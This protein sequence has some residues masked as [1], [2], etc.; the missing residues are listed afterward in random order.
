MKE[1]N[2]RV[3]QI[4]MHRRSFRVNE[5]TLSYL[6]SE[7]DKPV[8]VALHAHWM[9][10]ST[11]RHFASTLESSWRIVALDQR[12]HGYSDHTITY[13]R[14]DYINDIFNFLNHLKL[15]RVVLLGHSL[16]GVNAFQFAAR[17]PDRVRALIIEDIMPKLNVELENM[18]SPW[19]GIFST[20]EA[21]IS[22]IGQKMYPSLQ[23][24]I[25]ETA[26][27]WRLAFD[28]KD[29][30]KSIAS[31]NGDHGKDW[32][33]SD[34]PALIIRGKN[35][36]V[37]TASDFEEMASRRSNTELQTL[38]AGHSVHLDQPEKFTRILA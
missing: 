3:Q 15:N 25:R 12:G 23:D 34:C 16:G 19:G 9:E 14:E 35:S 38:D 28:I 4:E 10:A 11:Y 13:T 5:L 32:L 20:K 22:R 31:I 29:M 33:S 6:D 30:S 18:M 1:K 21:L 24:S 27:G 26:E 2:S 8:L 37:T 17:Y 7:V 36:G